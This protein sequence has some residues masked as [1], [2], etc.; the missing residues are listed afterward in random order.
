MEIDWERIQYFPNPVE[1]KLHISFLNEDNYRIC[2]YNLLGKNIIETKNQNNPTV[3][4]DM[5]KLTS[6]IYIATIENSL[7]E[8][9][10][11][12]IIKK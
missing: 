9:I 1:D 8:K 2:I 12:K 4:I 5:S 3:T 10:T 6:G 7:G 11:K